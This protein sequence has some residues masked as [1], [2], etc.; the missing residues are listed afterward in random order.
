MRPNCEN[1]IG[2]G[3]TNGHAEIQ[4]NER[5]D[6]QTGTPSH[7]DAWTHLKTRKIITYLYFFFPHTTFTI[8]TG[9]RCD[10]ELVLRAF[11]SIFDPKRTHFF[12]IRTWSMKS[13]PG[14][15]KMKKI[16]ILIFSFASPK[17]FFF[18]F[19]W[20][21]ILILNFFTTWLRYHRKGS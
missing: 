14:C 15:E 18:F 5:M 6:G 3:R 4:T 19:Y 11:L 20:K 8:L 21:N 13:E 2:N 9:Y 7:T 1:W 12:F 16:S 10:I 17:S